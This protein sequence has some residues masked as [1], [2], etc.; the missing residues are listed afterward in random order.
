MGDWRASV[1]IEFVL[2]GEKREAD[3]WINWD[4]ET[5]MDERVVEFFQQATEEIRTK[6]EDEEWRAGEAARVAQ[7]E[8]D[9]RAELERLTAKYGPIRTDAP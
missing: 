4:M 9:E 6:V 8:V 5:G 2:R 3:M 1:K 7:R